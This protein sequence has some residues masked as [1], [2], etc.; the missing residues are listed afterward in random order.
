LKGWTAQPPAEAKYV[1]GVDRRVM[2]F[3]LGAG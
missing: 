3:D 2:A 1:L